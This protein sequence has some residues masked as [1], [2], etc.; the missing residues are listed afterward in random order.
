[1]QPGAPGEPSRSL[2]AEE[3]EEIETP[4]HTDADVDFMQ[5]LIPTA[6]NIVFACWG[7]LKDH[8]PGEARLTR[9][10][11]LETRNAHLK[12]VAEAPD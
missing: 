3:A 6:E 1:M 9:L 5:G 7:Q 8:I 12:Q 2:S 11:L 4:P 10:R